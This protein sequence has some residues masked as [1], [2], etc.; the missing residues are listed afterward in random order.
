MEALE[1]AFFWLDA[2]FKLSLEETLLTTVSEVLLFALETFE[3]LLEAFIDLEL[4]ILVSFLVLDSD[5]FDTFLLVACFDSLVLAAFSL[6][7]LVSF[8]GFF[9]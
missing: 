5:F 2:V 8:S 4:F 1:V 9:S 7:S 3:V 6:L